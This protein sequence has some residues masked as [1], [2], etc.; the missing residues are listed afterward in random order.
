MGLQANSIRKLKIERKVVKQTEVMN[1]KKIS[2]LICA[3]AVPYD[4]VCEDLLH[5]FF[6][7]YSSGVFN[8]WQLVNDITYLSE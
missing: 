5:F 4:K 2:C 7:F 1:L 6:F 3:V 8:C